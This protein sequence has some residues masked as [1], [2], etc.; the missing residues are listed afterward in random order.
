MQTLPSHLRGILC[1]GSLAYLRKL[2][3]TLGVG[4][5]GVCSQRGQGFQQGRFLKSAVQ[6]AFKGE[7]ALGFW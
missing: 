2:K 1:R 6:A 4:F 3:L 7:G 5:G